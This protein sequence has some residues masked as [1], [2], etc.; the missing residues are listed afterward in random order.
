M[1]SKGRH[2]DERQRVPDLYSLFDQVSAFAITWSLCHFLV[3][4]TLR[5]H[6]HYITVIVLGRNMAVLSD[7]PL[8]PDDCSGGGGSR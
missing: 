5:C 6:R 1:L 7:E 8:K 4:V 3:T 2:S